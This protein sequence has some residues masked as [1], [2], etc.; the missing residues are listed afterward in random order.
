MKRR[1]FSQLVVGAANWQLG[2]IWSCRLLS[3]AKQSAIWAQLG[4]VC[5]R[6]VS[7]QETQR[8][9]ALL[10]GGLGGRL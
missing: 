3:P 1:L 9:A 5:L 10:T 4:P 6:L 7:L 2:P 8:Q